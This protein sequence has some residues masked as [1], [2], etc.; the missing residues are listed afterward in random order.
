MQLW[1]LQRNFWTSGS[2]PQK[3]VASFLTQTSFQRNE[4]LNLSVGFQ[5]F[6]PSVF[7]E[8]HL[9]VTGGFGWNVREMSSMGTRNK[10]SKFRDYLGKIDNIQLLEVKES[11]TELN[12]KISEGLR[13]SNAFLVYLVIQKAFIS[14]LFFRIFK[15]HISFKCG[16]LFIIITLGV[17]GIL[18]V[19]HLGCADS[20]TI[21]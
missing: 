16:L 17:A 19:K 4:G 21:N 3:P 6:V 11:T 12:H 1:N 9:S 5:A 18:A 7:A 2:E 13:S 14:S 15:L 20:P 10:W 8:V